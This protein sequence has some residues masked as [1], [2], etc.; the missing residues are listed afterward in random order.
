MH[1]IEHT[2]EKP[3]QCSPYDKCFTIKTNLKSHEIIPTG[4]KGNY[5][6]CTKEMKHLAGC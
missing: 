1:D 5:Q 2:G 4:K 6:I 3:Y